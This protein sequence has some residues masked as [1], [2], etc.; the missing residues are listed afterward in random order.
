MMT[1]LQLFGQCCS[2]AHMCIPVF[3]QPYG[4]KR[5]VNGIEVDIVEISGD[6]I[7]F[8]TRLRPYGN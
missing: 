1:L 8:T 6:T 4:P 5:V 3:G 2:I 7:Q